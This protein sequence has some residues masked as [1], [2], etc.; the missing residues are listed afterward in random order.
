M[1]EL[2]S[3]VHHWWPQ[4]ISQHWVGEDGF[5]GALR[6]DGRHF[7]TQHGKLGGIKNAHNMKLSPEGQ[8]SPWNHSFESLYDNADSAFPRI[9]DEIQSVVSSWMSADRSTESFEPVVVSEWLR[10]NLATSVVSLCLRGPLNRFMALGLA[11]KLREGKIS[12]R[13]QNTII[14]HNIQYMLKDYSRYM[15]G[16]GKVALIY[17][18]EQEFIFGDGFFHNLTTPGNMAHSPR[19][20]VPLTPRYSVIYAMPSSMNPNPMFHA[21]Y[22]GADVATQMNRTIQVYSKDELFYAN[23]K[24]CPGKDF[25]KSAFMRYEYGSNSADHLIAKIPGIVEI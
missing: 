11:M 1:N 9:I 7:R 20:I 13:E 17:S 22:V 16:R 21:C 12:P 25:L 18:P 2:K 10:Q 5:V 8:T 3:A 15:S 24:P 19:M 6:S 4:A 14:G 23:E